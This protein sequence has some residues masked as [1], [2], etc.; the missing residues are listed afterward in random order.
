MRLKLYALAFILTLCNACQS[1]EKHGGDVTDTD[2]ILSKPDTAQSIKPSADNPEE[3]LPV[4]KTGVSL[5]EIIPEGYSTSNE[6]YGQL[7]DDTLT[8]C[9][10]VINN[11]DEM[12]SKILVV[13]FKNANNTYD[14]SL[15][16]T[17]FITVRYDNELE[18]IDKKLIVHSDHP[19]H[20]TNFNNY[21]LRYVNN[22]WY[23]YYVTS[24]HDDANQSWNNEIDF[25]TG[26]FSVSHEV[27]TVDDQTHVKKV[28]GVLTKSA[29]F[30]ASNGSTTALE[31]KYEGEDYY[32]WDRNDLW[33]DEE[34]IK[35]LPKSYQEIIGGWSTAEKHPTDLSLQFDGNYYMNT[36]QEIRKQNEYM[37]GYYLIRHDSIFLDLDTLL[38]KRGSSGVHLKN[39]KGLIFTKDEE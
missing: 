30:I 37:N 2:S 35:L 23:C 31:I 21:T 11:Q 39:S 29:P 18:I 25:S 17:S 12:D 8:D 3:E 16:T 26:K 20:G 34:L 19:W 6:V 28:E 33:K 1:P 10:L 7:N 15:I 5:G 14:T 9:A 24:S 4:F 27:T 22:D 13:L 32:M 38:V 36:Y